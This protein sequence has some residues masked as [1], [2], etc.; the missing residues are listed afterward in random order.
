MHCIKSEINPNKMMIRSQRYLVIELL[1]K[2]LTPLNHRPKYSSL[3][4]KSFEYYLT[5]QNKERMLQGDFLIFYKGRLR[6]MLVRLSMN[7]V[8]SQILK[9]NVTNFSESYLNL[10]ICFRNKS[11]Q[12]QKVLNKSVQQKRSEYKNYRCQ[13]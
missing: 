1:N 12:K 8:I 6:R 9:I 3:S 11:R 5:L 7:N 13:V 4:Q 10:E 2:L